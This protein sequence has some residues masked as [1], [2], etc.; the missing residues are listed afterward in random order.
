M[1]ES[2]KAGSNLGVA[3]IGSLVLAAMLVLVPLSSL[4]AG[5]KGNETKG[6]F[7]FKQSCKSCHVKGEKGGEITPLSKTQAQW[8]AYFA[9]GK[10]MKGT[11]LLSKYMTEEQL[12]DALA[13][14]YNHAV[15]S[16]QPET[17]GK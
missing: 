3:I 11:E 17:C 14:V 4:S 13:F 8:Q 16:P 10:H 1:K 5:E 7:Y 6:K 2:R 12:K 9:K 15:D